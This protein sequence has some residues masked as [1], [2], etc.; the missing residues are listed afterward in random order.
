[1][2][3]AK[4]SDSTFLKIQDKYSNV[5]KHKMKSLHNQEYPNIV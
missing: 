5:H 2:S 3:P 1:M 4:P